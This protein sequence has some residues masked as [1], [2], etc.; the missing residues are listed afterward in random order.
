MVFGNNLFVSLV[1]EFSVTLVAA[2]VVSA[3]VSL[4]ITPAL[5]GRYLSQVLERL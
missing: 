4:T 3:V 1:R 5:C 2:I